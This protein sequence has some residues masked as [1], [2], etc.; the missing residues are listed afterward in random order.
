MWVRGGVWVLLPRSAEAIVAILAVLK[1]GA[2]YVP[3]DPAHPDERIGFVLADAAPL[4]VIT[5]AQLRV[6][7]E[8]H[9][10][11]DRRC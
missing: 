7:L 10:L 1:C 6:R 5:D 8:G 11:R 2:A 9:D 4:V 3:I